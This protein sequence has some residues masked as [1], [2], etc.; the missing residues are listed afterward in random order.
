[1]TQELNQILADKVDIQTK[2]DIINM[3]KDK[4]SKKHGDFRGKGNKREQ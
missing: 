1:M 3:E 2:L 4:D